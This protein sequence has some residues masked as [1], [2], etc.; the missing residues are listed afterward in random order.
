MSRPF[1]VHV[2]SLPSWLDWKRLLG[3]GSWTTTEKDD[4]SLEAQAVLARNDA[5][6]LAARLRGVGLGGAMLMLTISPPLARK[7]LRKALTEEARRYRKSSKGFTKA[8]T[9]VDA[10]GRYSLTPEVIA[11]ELGKRAQGLR[12]IDACAGAGGNA[13]GFAR[14]GCEVVAI[15]LDP[16]RLAMAKHNAKVY[17]VTKRIQFIVG[18]ARELVSSLQADLL[19]V[20]P[21]WGE[22]YNK[23]RVTLS[24][25]AP[26]EEIMN[27]ARHIPRAW[28]KTPPSFDPST[29]PSYRPEAI[30]GEATGDERRVKFLLLEKNSRTACTMPS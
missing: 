16:S 14:A 18:D 15:E 11:Y 5:A 28:I 6:D 9:R 30:F 25:L 23:E 7:D 24:D 8:S 17:G 12:I 26:C 4:G 20:D 29:L 22:K 10:E 3:P 21:P 27:R 19:F 13:I 2:S 1:D